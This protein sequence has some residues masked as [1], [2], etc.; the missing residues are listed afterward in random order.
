MPP[1][2]HRKNNGHAC[3]RNKILLRYLQFKLSVFSLRVQFMYVCMLRIMQVQI[4]VRVK[5]YASAGDGVS[6]EAM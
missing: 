3:V 4:R 6:T 1:T 2:L 5:K